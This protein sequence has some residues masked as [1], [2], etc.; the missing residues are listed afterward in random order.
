MRTDALRYVSEATPRPRRGPAGGYGFLQVAGN[1]GVHLRQAGENGILLSVS[2]CTSALTAG[3]TK[4]KGMGTPWL[5]PSTFEC[6]SCQRMRRMG[7][8]SEGASVSFG[9]PD[10]VPRSVRADVGCDLRRG[11]PKGTGGFWPLTSWWQNWERAACC[12]SVWQ[13]SPRW[14]S[15]RFA[16]RT[17]AG[18][19]GGLEGGIVV[20]VTGNEDTK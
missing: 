16:M 5:S 2:C 6:A 14:A 17:F 13:S 10:D 4:V 18:A 8:R 9:G 7:R 12:S 15:S 1:V 3:L 11:W 19:C 20:G